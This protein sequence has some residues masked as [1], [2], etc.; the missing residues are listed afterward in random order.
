[1]DMPLSSFMTS[2]K[3]DQAR[4]SPLLV[5]EGQANCACWGQT[6]KRVPGVDVIISC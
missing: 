5:H 2:F 3:Y 6:S 4:T 1:M